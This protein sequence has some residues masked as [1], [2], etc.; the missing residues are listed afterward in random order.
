MDQ[1]QAV[2]IKQYFKVEWL[3]RQNYHPMISSA[4]GDETVADL[5]LDS[6]AIFQKANA[7]VDGTLCPCVPG[8]QH[9]PK[10]RQTPLDR[11]VRIFRHM[12][13][14]TNAVYQYRAAVDKMPRPGHAVDKDL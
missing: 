10:T 12:S 7:P 11:L 4:L 9:V 2:Y 13:C 6:V 8:F 14:I 5:I 3:A 1:D